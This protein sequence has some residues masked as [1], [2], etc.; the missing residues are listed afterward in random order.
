MAEARRPA[1]T[2]SRRG[3]GRVRKLPSGRVQAAY[4]G[5]D[6]QVHTAPTT[7]STTLDAEGWLRDERRLIELDEWTPPADRQAVRRVRG[8]TLDEYSK[9]WLSHRRNRHG[10]PLK[11]RTKDLYQK[12]L[13]QHILP[14]FGALP[15]RAITEAMVDDWFERLLPEAPTRRAHT[16]ALLST[17]MKSAAS[18]KPKPLI[19]ANPCRI[20]G[21]SKVDR[22]FEPTPATPAELATLAEAMPEKYRLLVL[23]GSWC[24]LRFGELA[25]LRRR[26]LDPKALT[27]KVERAVVW[28]NGSTIVGTPKSRAGRRTVAIPPHLADDVRRHLAQHAQPGRDGLLFPNAAGTGH[29][30][31]ST[32]MKPF[33]KAREAAGRPD[34]RIHDL[35]HTGATLAAQSGATLRELMV[36]IGHSTPDAAMRYQHAAAE[37]DKAIAAALSEM[38]EAGR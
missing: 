34:L 16:Y 11:P 7:F 30:H 2:R 3:F 27:V 13:D 31:P 19:A 12:L 8:L 26:D 4:A 14:T 17:I 9:E 37:R 29:I 15:L 21:A 32:V 24:G 10:E 20:T 35:R 36:R 23:L 1:R 6:R 22:T 5:P 28:L 38:A 18:A 25:E 33:R